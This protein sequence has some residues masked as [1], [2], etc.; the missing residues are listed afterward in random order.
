MMM[1]SL[2]EKFGKLIIQPRPE[3]PAA[4]I[5]N[6]PRTMFIPCL[7][8]VLFSWGLLFSPSLAFSATGDV[9]SSFAAPSSGP[10]GMAWDGTNLWVADDNTDLIYEI[11]TAGSVISTIA[12]PCGVPKGLAFDGTNLWPVCAGQNLIY[13]MTPTGSIISTIPT[14]AGAVRGITWDGTNLWV[15][16]AGT[17]LIYEVTTAGSVLSS[18]STPGT[19]PRGLTYV[20]IN[21]WIAENVG[22]LVFEMTTAGSVLSSFS[23]PAAVPRG[24]TFDGT[25]FWLSDNG[26]DL[27]YQLEGPAPCP[28]VTTTADSGPGSLRQCIAYANSN[29]GTTIIFDIPDTAPGYTTSGSES[30]WRI[31]PASALPTITA[32]GTIIDGTTQAANY[33]SD[34]NSLGPEIE[35][36][37]SGAGAGA[38]G[39]TVNVPAGSAT[40]RHLVLD[41]FDLSGILLQGGSTLVAGCYMGLE[42]DGDTLAGNNTSTTSYHGGIRIESAGNT[43]GG[44][45]AAD[46]NIISGNTLAGIVMFSAA[47]TGNQVLGNYIGLDAGGTLDRGNIS[48]GE[49]IEFQLANSNSIGGTSAGARNVIS[50]NASDGMEIDGS[51]FNVIQGNYIGT[52]YTGTVAIPNDRDGIDINSDLATGSVGNIIGGTAPGAGN[53]ISGNNL[54]GVELRDDTVVGSTTDNSILGNLIYGNGQLGIDLEPVGVTANDPGEG[55]PGPNGLQNYPVIT[56]VVSGGVSTTVSGTLN[57]YANT[58]FRLEFYSTSNPDPLGY[59][60]GDAFLGTTSVTTD[61]SGDASFTVNFPVGIAPGDYVTA[62]ATG[63]TGSTSEFSA[64]AVLP[65]YL[66]KQAVLATDGSLITNSST[67]PRGTVF[68]FLIYTENTGAARTDVSIRDVLDP[69]FAYSDGSLKVDNSAAVGASVQAIYTAVNGTAPLTDVIDADVVSIAGSTIDAGNQ[70]VGNGPLDIAANRIWALLFTVRMQ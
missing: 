31:T 69:A 40:I 32:S 41:N 67:L 2:I 70:Y 68:K 34:T 10:F 59:G 45:S 46:R 1:N 49:G 66:T 35:I 60:E 39:L 14:P 12:A 16:D 37:G 47:A 52:D 6:S 44:T 62:T 18:F 26:T 53:L 9:L 57:S 50:G 23:A 8:F 30:W 5:I 29:A 7:F 24:L 51:S 17:G 64:N 28:T 48:D 55:I 25:D 15:D 58:T 61:G 36:D 65:L 4:H 42:P 43:I 38:N 56:A 20:G 63:P 54:N 22:D 13:E 27:I 3:R 19:Q 11:T 21:L 33:G